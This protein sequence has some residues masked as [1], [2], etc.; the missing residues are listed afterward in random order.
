MPTPWPQPPPRNVNERAAL[1]E[2][3][4]G[5]RPEER[6]DFGARMKGRGPRWSAI[7]DLFRLH[8]RRL[9]L[10]T[11]SEAMLDV[12]PPERGPEWVQGELFG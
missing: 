2:S 6:G 9:G 7:E 5:F 10:D 12:L 4:A 8:C 11:T 3:R 1:E